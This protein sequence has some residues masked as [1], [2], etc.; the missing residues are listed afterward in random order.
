[1]Y[2][3]TEEMNM[4]KDSTTYTDESGEAQD[5]SEPEPAEPSITCTIDEGLEGI[6]APWLLSHVQK[7]IEC[8]GLRPCSIALRVVGDEEMTSLHK[9]HS[10][11]DATTDVLT[12][13]RGSSEDSI[14]AD[15]AICS[16]EANRLATQR[17]HSL[18]EELLLYIVHGM[19]HCVGYDD[20]DEESY[21]K[22]HAEE[23]RILVA[24][25]VG[26]VWS[27]TQ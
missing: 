2:A 5:A 7:A 6:D 9:A 12:F 23:D 8:I 14:E 15:I 16:D 10:S 19:L 18:N 22:M 11:I 24:I 21:Q 3:V 1:M 13:D 25:G 17:D 20:H 4:H 26:P 27:R